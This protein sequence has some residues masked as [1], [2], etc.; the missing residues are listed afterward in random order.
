MFSIVFASGDARDPIYT[1]RVDEGVEHTDCT[2]LVDEEQ[3][4]KTYVVR[5]GGWLG[6]DAIHEVEMQVWHVVEDA[7]KT[8]RLDR[9]VRPDVQCASSERSWV[10]MAFIKVLRGDSLPLGW[11]P[12]HVV[13]LEDDRDLSSVATTC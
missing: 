4:V 13:S 10:R 6:E 1:L 9:V 3:V 8:M 7:R 5:H 2:L 12:P 11:R